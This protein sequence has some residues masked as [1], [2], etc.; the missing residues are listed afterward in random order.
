MKPLYLFFLI[1]LLLSNSLYAQFKDGYI[2]NNNNDTIRGMI[3]FKESILKS[4]QCQFK[5]SA[6]G[7]VTTYF[8]KDIKAFRFIGSKYFTT[9]EISIDSVPRKVFLEWLIKGKASVLTYSPSNGKPRFFI[10]TA[11]DSLLELQNTINIREINGYHDETFNKE[12]I[13]TLRYYFKDKISLFPQIERTVLNRNSLIKIT[14][15][16]NDKADGNKESI[17]NGGYNC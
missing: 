9:S 17:I 11:K 16:Y 13:G 10:L 15:N 2:V 5:V 3:D 7:S 12:Y 6:T 1:P 14:K 8:P 4:D